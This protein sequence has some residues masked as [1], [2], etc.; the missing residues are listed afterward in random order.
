MVN[1]ETIYLNNKEYYNTK[2]LLKNDPT[3][4]Y[5]CRNKVRN[6][7]KKKKI[8]EEATHYG[9]KKGGVWI[10]SKKSYSKALLLL[11]CDWARNNIPSM[12]RNNKIEKAP[13]IL[14]L[15]DSE[16]LTDVD[17]NIMNIETRGEKHINKCYFLVKDVS[18]CFKMKNLNSTIKH[19]DKGYTKDIHY[20]KFTVTGGTNGQRCVSRLYLTYKGLVRFLYVSRNKNA[21]QFQDWANKILFTVQMGKIEDKKILSSKLL[22]VHADAVRE[23]FK[24]SAKTMPCIYLFILGSAKNLRDE[25]KINDKYEDN[26]LVCKYGYTKD[27]SRRTGEH[28]RE[29][30]KIN[31]KYYSYIDPQYVSDA[32]N[33]VRSFFNDALEVKFDY[34]DYEELVIL[35][36]SQLKPVQGLYNQISSSYAGH[37]TELIKQIEDLKREKELDY[38]KHENA[39]LIKDKELDKEKHKNILLTKENENALLLKDLEI[40]KLQNKLLRNS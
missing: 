16:K 37:S 15:H 14:E 34:K 39:L 35:K 40:L 32:E 23:V 10:D 28:M 11:T 24:V 17:G 25:M 20:K 29:Y 12:M 5:G 30:G 9:Y 2:E 36:P 18:R 7:I 13:E 6:I 38:Q 3:Y 1:L 4:F 31:L 26:Y 21:E 33:D 8:K 27:L 22:G 19:K